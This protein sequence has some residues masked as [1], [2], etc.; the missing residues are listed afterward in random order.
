[1][2][3]LMTFKTL[4]LT[5]SIVFLISLNGQAGA[6]ILV[7]QLDYTFSGTSPAGTSPWMTA[8]FDD[9]FGGPNTVRLTISANNLV[10]N[11]SATHV[12]F[13]FDPTLDPTLLSF[14]AINNSAAVPNNIL[15]GSNSYKADGD[16]YYDINF[17]LPPPPGDFASRLSAGESIIYDINYTSAINAS[18]F[19]FLS[20]EGGGNGIY[21]S[22]AH[23]QDISGGNSGW[24]GTT[25]VVPEPISSTLFIV[26]GAVL[27][28]R[29]FRK[30]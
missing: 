21:K 11:E 28:F 13:N 16:G 20:T 4:L 24:I 30:R 7:H 29:R 6:D 19:N 5:L 15:T 2:K 3:N 18:S 9:S 1:M 27:G 8:T 10:V 23:I 17:D 12:Y 25:T 14:T 26:G 22:A